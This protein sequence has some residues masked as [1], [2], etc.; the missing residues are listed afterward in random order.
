MFQPTRP[1]KQIF[2]LFLSPGC[3]SLCSMPWTPEGSLIAGRVPAP[4]GSGKHG[5]P[6]GVAW[7]ARMKISRSR[8]EQQ[9][10]YMFCCWI[11]NSCFATHRIHVLL[12]NI[13]FMF[14]LFKTYVIPKLAV[15]KESEPCRSKCSWKKDKTNMGLMLS[16]MKLV[17]SKFR[18]LGRSLLAWIAPWRN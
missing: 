17:V 16:S 10:G 6:T 8:Y 11:L 9:L 13:E 14:C 3:N 15:W 1:N 4:I 5:E 18:W 7:R 2:L 12:L